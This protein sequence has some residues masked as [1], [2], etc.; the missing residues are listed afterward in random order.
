MLK[1]V[2]LCGI[3]LNGEWIWDESLIELFIMGATVKVEELP[4]GKY[5]VFHKWKQL[6]T[7]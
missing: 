6:F 5:A 3:R 1:K 2:H 7:F 4:N